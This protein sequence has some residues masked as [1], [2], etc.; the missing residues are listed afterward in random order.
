MA[1]EL[2]LPIKIFKNRPF[3]D[4]K[5]K[6][7]Q[8]LLQSDIFGSGTTLTPVGPTETRPLKSVSDHFGSSETLISH[9]EVS[10]VNSPFEPR[11]CFG[12]NP[13]VQILNLSTDKKSLILFANSQF[14]VL[15]NFHE[16]TMHFM[17]GHLNKISCLARNS[18]GSLLVSADSGPNS[19][20]IIWDS[21][22]CVVEVLENVHPSG[23]ILAGMSVTGEYLVT[24]SPLPHPLV[25]VWIWRE[26]KHTP[27]AEKYIIES[28][29]DVVE[30]V[31]N[32]RCEEEFVLTS[33]LA[34]FFFS[35]RK[36]A[37][38]PSERLHCETLHQIHSRLGTFTDTTYLPREAIALS[39]TS[40]GYVIVWEGKDKLHHTIHHGKHIRLHLEQ[41][42][43]IEVV[44]GVVAIATVS[45]NIR[46]YDYSLKFLWASKEQLGT[47]LTLSF[48]LY[49]KAR[50]VVH[51]V[52]PV[53]AHSSSCAVTWRKETEQLI[54]ATL[55]NN[56]LN[57]R[58]F[59]IS[60]KNGEVAYFNSTKE[61][62]KKMLYPSSANYTA[63][64]V[65]PQSPYICAGTSEG[66]VILID[67][68]DCKIKVTKQL[69][70]GEDACKAVSFLRYSPSGLVLACAMY[71][72]EVWLLDPLLLTPRY[73]PL[74]NCVDC[75]THLVFSPRSDYFAVADTGMCITVFYLLDPP[76]SVGQFKAHSKVIRDILFV[77]SDD[78]L[79]LFTVGEDRNIVQFEIVNKSDVVTDKVLKFFNIHRAEQSAV[80]CC[81]VPY[82]L[83]EKYY[84]MVNTEMKFKFLEADTLR[85]S[86]T[87]Q[88]PNLESS[89]NFLECFTGDDQP[90]L[91]FGTD[92]E[93]GLHIL[94]PDGNPYKSLAYRMSPARIIC[95]RMHSHGKYMFTISENCSVIN[96]WKI[97]TT[98]VDEFY[99]Q[100]GVGLDPFLSLLEG[101]KGGSQVKDLREFLPLRAVHTSGRAT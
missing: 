32:P 84:L 6:V 67:F 3:L 86:K 49:G 83:D 94:P 28:Y 47:L 66:Q 15:Y 71:S 97:N 38:N 17:Q 77:A 99:A 74:T 25:Q 31:M 73:L 11:W 91:L 48:N 61:I 81:I 7:E 5:A 72:G 27:A 88:A 46:F 33:Q 36:G 69:P 64:D 70:I 51:A 93:I 22:P 35:F 58:H 9:D 13:D 75:I 90:Y 95:C 55:Q 96:M 2:S 1:K 26:D 98:A 68:C 42:T 21:R 44:D 50:D 30:L 87:I 8:V 52:C 14:P 23:T 57:V 45:G 82:S 85:C 16:D 79:R 53:P 100:G 89:I 62:P 56:P 12:F 24:V 29:G 65:M 92:Q 19:R 18:T 40:K 80:P 4:T 78:R 101:G 60:T 10:H 39:S 37:S 63:I 34:V 59:I 41:I 20:V 43:H 76:V 54:D